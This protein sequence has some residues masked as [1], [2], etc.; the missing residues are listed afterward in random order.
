MFARFT[1][2]FGRLPRGEHRLAARATA[3][4]GETRTGPALVV[5]SA[6]H[7]LPAGQLRNF[8][9]PVLASGAAPVR[10]SAPFGAYARKEAGRLVFFAHAPSSI[11]YPAPAGAARLRGRFGFQPGAYAPENPGRTDGAEFIIVWIEPNGRRT[12]LLRRHL[13]P[14]EEPADRGEHDFDLP[15]PSA[16]P[17]CILEL[18]ITSGPAGSPASDWTYWSDLQLDISR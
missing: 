2:P 11:S 18:V 16:A 12:E 4:T 5:D 1:V 9:L 14:T 8:A 10:L 7:A 3:A 6:P 13:R 15:L 17:G